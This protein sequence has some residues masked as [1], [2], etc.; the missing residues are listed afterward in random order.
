MTGNSQIQVC[1]QLIKKKKRTLQRI[2]KT[3]SWF[4]EKINK[5][6]KPFAKPIRR[7]RT[8][9]Q[10]NKIRNKKGAITTETEKIQSMKRSYFKSIYWTSP[11]QLAPA[12]VHLGH[13]VGGHTQ[14]P[15]EDSPHDLRTTC[16]WNTTSVPI[17]SHRT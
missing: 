7:H 2:N 15:L 3:K 14:G 16:E 5:I 8:S 6:D 12:P 11:F 1:D 9:I 4:F 17:Q 10:I 13:R